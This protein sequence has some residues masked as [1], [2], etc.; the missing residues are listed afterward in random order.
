MAGDGVG[1]AA[2]AFNISDYKDEC[3]LHC[4]LLHGVQGWM[5]QG[6]LGAVAISSLLYKRHIERPIRSFKVC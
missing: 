3:S 2:S 6:I 4:C 5:V 1:L